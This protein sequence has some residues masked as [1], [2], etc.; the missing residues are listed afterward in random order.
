LSNSERLIIPYKGLEYGKHELEFNVGDIFFQSLDYSEFD[1]GKVTIYVGLE[2]K[3]THL[4]LQIEIEGTVEVI[5]DRCLDKFNIEVEYSGD[6]FIKFSGNL[7]SDDQSNEELL[8]LSPDDFEVD[9]THYLY[10]SICL[11][12]PYTRVHPSNAKG[13]SLCN[14]EMLKVIK[15]HSGGKVQDIDETDPRWEKLRNLNNN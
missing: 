2:K 5:C 15:E 1:H 9:L 8:V 7:E 6:L 4:V 14:K 10:E 3:P 12:I 13:K 11:G